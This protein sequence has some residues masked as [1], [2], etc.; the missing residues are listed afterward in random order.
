M[1]NIGAN[2][3]TVITIE[4]G[5]E[6]WKYIPSTIVVRKVDFIMKGRLLPWPFVLFGS[7]ISSLV[8]TEKMVAATIHGNFKLC[9]VCDV[10]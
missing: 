3:W 10:M 6:E 8:A 1:Y 2:A 7:F 4:E 5:K 9:D